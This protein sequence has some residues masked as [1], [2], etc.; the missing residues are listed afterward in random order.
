MG[1]AIMAAGAAAIDAFGVEPSNVQVTRHDLLVPQLP[2]ALEG[3]VVAHVT[4]VHLPRGMAAA[5]RT[6]ELL[7]IE[8]PDVVLL[9]GDMA[10]GAAAAPALAAFA[11]SVRGTLA[12]AAVM[13][14][15]EYASGLGLRRTRAAYRQA[16]VPLLINDGHVLEVGDARL[17]IS[18]F[19]D[20]IWGSP[21]LRRGAAA[22]RDAEVRIW[23]VHEPVLVDT[24]PPSVA[25]PDLVLAGHTHGGQV[26][27]PLIGKLVV[28]PGS[29]RYVQGWYRGGAAPLYVTRGIGTS[30]INVRFLCRPELALFTLR[31]ASDATSQT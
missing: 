30:G 3:L 11:R 9:G 20:V 5:Q 16:G 19:D 18:G 13:G 23:L 6:I 8:R 2:R 14:N 12:T 31:R 21:D 25:A 17:G 22:A 7:A 28:P 27:L 1:G 24:V 15:W 26:R 10:E 29:G 4:D